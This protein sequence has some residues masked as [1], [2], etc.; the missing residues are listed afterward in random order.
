MKGLFAMIRGQ[1]HGEYDADDCSQKQDTQYE[2]KEN[3]FS[4][5]EL[6]SLRLTNP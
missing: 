4:D 3:H 2:T 5:R 1:K 6:L